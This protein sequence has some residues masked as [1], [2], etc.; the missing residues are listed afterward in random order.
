MIKKIKNLLEKN[1]FYRFI[2]F[3]FI[4]GTS[5]FIS[6]IFFN[7]FFKIFNFIIK[8]NFLIFNASISYVLSSLL[9][10]VISMVYNFSMNRN[11]TF[12]AKYEPIKKQIPKYLTV[13]L[14]SI[15]IGFFSSL[16]ILNLLGKENTLNANISIISGIII[17]IPF[18]FFGSLL[19]TFRKK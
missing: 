17:S 10:T 2:S 11:I 14:I 1:N 6:L 13:Y 3:C 9:G 15:T 8:S 12:S 19:W 18:S 5:A 7:I 4:G 16:F